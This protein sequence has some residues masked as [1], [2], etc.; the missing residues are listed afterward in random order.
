MNELKRNFISLGMGLK[1]LIYTYLSISLSYDILA[2]AAIYLL[3]VYTY[4]KSVIFVVCTYKS[5]S[6]FTVI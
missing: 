6:Q 3:F 1:R 4:F 5:L 2:E